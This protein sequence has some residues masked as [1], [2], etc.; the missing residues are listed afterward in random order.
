[1]LVVRKK[2]TQ[3]EISAAALRYNTSCDCVQQSPDNGATWIDVPQA[4]P[5]HAAGYRLPASTSPD[6]Q[7]DAA[8]RIVGAWRDTLTTLYASVNA[9]TFATQVLGIL[10]T[11]A[12]GVGVLL[13]LIFQ[14]LSALV[15]IGVA[16]IEAAFTEEQWHSIQCII[17][18][19]IGADGQVSAGEA[20]AILA[21][22]ASTQPAIVYNVLVELEQLFGEVL[23]SNAGVER[24]E[25][26]DCADCACAWCADI[27]LTA[28]DFDMST[29][30]TA[31]GAGAFYVAGVGWTAHVDA[32]RPLGDCVTTLRFGRLFPNTTI[33]KFQM[34]GDITFG[35]QSVFASFYKVTIGGNILFDI[36]NSDVSGTLTWEGAISTG[37]DSHLW[38]DVASSGI[39]YAYAPPAGGGG[40]ITHL[41]IEGT[42]AYPF[43]LWE[44]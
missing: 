16:D 22:I 27:D 26:G 2:L 11:L 7:C 19:H 28:S 24:S 15:T 14:V 5:R 9:A 44:C 10:L 41:H 4:D 1:M 38:W 33:T 8:A 21:D 30:D 13:D 34:T 3:N 25:T 17:D 23:M 40:T 12:G 39:G 20:A 42:G 31:F 43:L 18:C 37:D 35:D 29:E 36:G 32:T 6:A